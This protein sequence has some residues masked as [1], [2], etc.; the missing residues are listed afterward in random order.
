M[1]NVRL[2]FNRFEEVPVYVMFIHEYTVP[3]E[4]TGRALK[5]DIQEETFY[6]EKDLIN[7]IAELQ[8]LW[9][10]EDF[11]RFDGD[12]KNEIN[13]IFRMVSEWKDVKRMYKNVGEI[14]GRYRKENKV[15]QKKMSEIAG[16]TTNH[17][18]KIERK[19]CIPN[20]G[21]LLTYIKEFDIPIEEVLENEW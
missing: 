3:E 12:K 5:R 14:L 18:S 13:Y 2:L 8:L 1:K 16:V 19:L 20:A 11:D 6:S 7:R 10:V 4:W 9:H 17:I 21:I 15:T